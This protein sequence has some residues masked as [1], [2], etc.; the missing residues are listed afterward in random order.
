MKQ[1]Q[2]KLL[3]ERRK[4][5]SQVEVKN[6]SQ[7]ICERLKPYLKGVC[8]LYCAYGNEVQLDALFD[9]CHCVLPIVDNDSEMHF[10]YYD[11]QLAYQDGAYHI[12]E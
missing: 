6:K 2:R 3:K 1:R 12:R 4:N 8:A 5:L 10:V 7:L 9:E 11:K